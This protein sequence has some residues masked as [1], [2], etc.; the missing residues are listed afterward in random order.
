MQR[1]VAIGLVALLAS[2]VVGSSLAF[3]DVASREKAVEGLSSN[4]SRGSVTIATEPALDHGR[5]VFRVT[6]VNRTDQPVALTDGDV[7]VFTVSGRQVGLVKLERLIAEVRGETSR[8]P[9]DHDDDGTLD[10]RM[11]TMDR[12]R[13]GPLD[14]TPRSDPSRDRGRDGPLPGVTTDQWP[15]GSSVSVQAESAGYRAK[16]DAL[17]ESILKAKVVQPSRAD[18]GKLVTEKLRFGRKDEHA[19]RVRVNF[20]GEE[21]EFN[22]IPPES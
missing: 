16:V 13:Q 19:L 6:G 20:A 17:K 7:K 2:S 11:G 8:R 14:R 3:A 10:D 22:F 4:K 21:H 5:L 18:G 15:D 12:D 9:F 1:V